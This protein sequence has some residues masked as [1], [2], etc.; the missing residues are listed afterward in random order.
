[1]KFLAALLLLVAAVMVA[2]DAYV[3]PVQRPFP[4]H[5]PFPSFP[6]QGPFNPK[7]PVSSMKR[8]FLILIITIL[9]GTDSLFVI[10]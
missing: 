8:K 7:L 1:M 3:P 9:S 2:V 4:N 5:R 6:G 10:L